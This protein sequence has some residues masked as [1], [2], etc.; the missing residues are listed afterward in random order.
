MSNV[1][2]IAEFDKFCGELPENPEAVV[3]AVEE[4]LNPK[5]PPGLQGN[6]ERH[7][8][9]RALGVVSIIFG[10]ALCFQIHNSLENNI[11]KNNTSTIT[12]PNPRFALLAVVFSSK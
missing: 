2:G 6:Y 5:K 9:R 12:Q 11:L 7:F 10:G 4:L 8:W 3:K 1:E